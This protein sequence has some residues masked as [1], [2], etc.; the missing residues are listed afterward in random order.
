MNQEIK[1]TRKKQYKSGNSST[2]NMESESW[3]TKMSYLKQ[4]SN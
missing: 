4:M 1:S 2:P 3:N